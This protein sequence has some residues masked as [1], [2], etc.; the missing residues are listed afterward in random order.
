MIRWVFFDIGWTLV[1][2]TEAHRRRWQGVRDLLAGFGIGCSVDDLMGLLEEASTAFA[3]SPFLY[4]LE[5]MGLSGGQ[6]EEIVRY[7][8]FDHKH[9]FFY[10]GACEM[11]PDLARAYSLGII[12]NQ[13]QGTYDRLA[14]R[15]IASAFPVVIASAEF[16]VSK[17]DPRIFEAAI[18]RAGCEP[19]EAVMVGDRLDNDIGPAKRLGWRTIRVRQGLARLQEPREPAEQAD[20][21][22]EA[23]AE[24]PGALAKPAKGAILT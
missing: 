13:S 6:R 21:T 16:G 5:K 24:L 20:C 4:A 8:R 2:E 23:I 9:E 18:A 22:I 14:E 10:P 15:G 17:P 11:L 19:H 1:D 12:A 3:R 7:A